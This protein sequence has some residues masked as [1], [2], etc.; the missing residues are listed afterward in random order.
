MLFG[1]LKFYNVSFVLFLR[2]SSSSVKE[3]EK[4]EWGEKWKKENKYPTHE[5]LY[6]VRK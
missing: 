4:R 3:K 6:R 1:L 2:A 5:K